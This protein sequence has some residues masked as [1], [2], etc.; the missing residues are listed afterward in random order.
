MNRFVVLAF[1]LEPD[2]WGTVVGMM[3]MTAALLIIPFVD[4]SDHEP[5]TW[6]EALDLRQR[7][8]AFL[9]MAVFWVT[10]IIGVLTN[11]ITPVG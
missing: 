5:A 7:G 2:I 6:G 4:R 1:H 8:W 3:L 9:A 10:M 11:A